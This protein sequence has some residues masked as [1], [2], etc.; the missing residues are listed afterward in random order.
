[1]KNKNSIGLLE[2]WISAVFWIFVS[3]SWYKRI[4]FR[5]LTNKTYIESLF[6]M[7]GIIIITILIAIFITYKYNKRGW[8]LASLLLIAYGIYTIISYKNIIGVRIKIILSISTILALIYSVLIMTR[9]IRFKKNG[10]KLY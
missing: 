5:C 7:Y 9:K 6:V 10:L 1:M 2:F 8:Y 3:L 4:L